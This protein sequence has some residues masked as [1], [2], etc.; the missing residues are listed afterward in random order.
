MGK[1]QQALDTLTRSD[2]IQSALSPG[3]RPE[4]IAFLAMAQFKLAQQEQAQTLLTE[5]RQLMRQPQ[6]SGNAEAQR[7]LREATDLIEGKQ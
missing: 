2:R 7:F 6:W 4:D 1:L 3:R 5:L